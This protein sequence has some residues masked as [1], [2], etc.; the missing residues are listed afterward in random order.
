MILNKSELMK[1]YSSKDDE[2][3]VS[4]WLLLKEVMVNMSIEIDSEIDSMEM[5]ND[6][7]DDVNEFKNII[8]SELNWLVEES[9]K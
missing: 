5:L 1:K 3:F 7:M 2:R 9:K 6:L 4:N 8:D